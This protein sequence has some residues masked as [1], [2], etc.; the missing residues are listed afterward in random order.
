MNLL[1]HC[2]QANEKLAKLANAEK[3]NDV[4]ENIRNRS[5]ELRE[6]SESLV[7]VSASAV[8][9]LDA[10]I[11]KELQLI[12]DSKPRM[13]LTEIR[14]KLKDD[15]SAITSGRT[16]TNLKKSLQTYT[17]K[18]IQLINSS[19]MEFVTEMSPKLDSK[20]LKQHRNTSFSDTVLKLERNSKEA[21][22]IAKDTP[23]DALAFSKLKEL[24]AEIRED[25]ASLPQADDPEVQAFLIAVGS[26]TGAGLGLLTDSVRTWLLENQMIED[27]SVRRLR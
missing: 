26:E 18:A 20:L 1:E 21:Q 6:T 7:G 2:K 24:W 3:A 25:L 12:D 27:F 22:K 14:Q 9:L 19:W 10:G 5:S 8:V 13:H 15:P 17:E 23:G 11:L 16:F 4:A